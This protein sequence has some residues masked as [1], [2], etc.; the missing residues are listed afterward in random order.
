MVR[1]EYNWCNISYICEMLHAYR[2]VSMDLS[3]T[4]ISLDLNHCFEMIVV[5]IVQMVLSGF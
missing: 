2:A 4:S 1:Q 3:Y 5:L